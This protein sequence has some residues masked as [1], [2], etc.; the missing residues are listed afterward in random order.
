M[1][2]NKAFLGVE[3]KKFPADNAKKATGI[4]YRKNKQLVLLTNIGVG[5]TDIYPIRM[6]GLTSFFNESTVY[7]FFLPNL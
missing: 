2:L 1:F 6:K 3:K 5:G 4:I 7:W